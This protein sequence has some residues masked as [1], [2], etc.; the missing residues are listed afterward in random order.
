MIPFSMPDS[1]SSKKTYFILSKPY[2]VLCQ[3]TGAKGQH[4]LAEFGPFPPDVYP[5]GR[6]DAD[7]EG[8]VLLTNDGS[9]KHRLLNPDFRHP[10]EYL[11]QVEGVPAA[12]T[13]NLLRNGVVISG[14]QTLP[15]EAE[16]LEHEPS[17]P[18]RPRPVRYRKSIP[19]SWLRITLREGKNRQV[20]RMTAAAGFPTLR[21]VRTA[22]GSITLKDLAPGESRQL[23]EPEIGSLQKLVGNE[24]P[25]S[26]GKLRRVER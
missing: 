26:A 8:L 13:I 5:A 17:L 14:Y 24:K 20:R 12:E 10:R 21:L 25:G 11:V 7:S 6:L 18:P 9:L 3:F 15:C 22:I 19:T 4:T 2:G 23:T 16:L 1:Q